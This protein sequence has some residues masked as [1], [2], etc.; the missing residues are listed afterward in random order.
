MISP[1]DMVAAVFGV[2]VAAFVVWGIVRIAND[3]RRLRVLTPVAV[4][5]ACLWLPFSW[6][7]LTHGGWDSY[8]LSWLRMWPF[9]PGF[10]PGALL[11][12]PKHD[13]LAF[14]TM[15][16]TTL[17]MMIGLTWLGCRSRGG[18]IAAAAITM[19]ISVPTALIAYTAYLF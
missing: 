9:L 3:R 17:I 16:I 4:V 18:L 11:F 1:S 19:L 2:V 5:A 14:S 10:L 7:I 13:L 15:A 12:L 6:L 8:R